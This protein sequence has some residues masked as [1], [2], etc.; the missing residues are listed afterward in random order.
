MRSPF[1]WG[2]VALVVALLAVT[3]GMAIA[4]SGGSS[5]SS[6]S[7]LRSV[8]VAI[9][10]LEPTAQVM[11]AKERGF[12][13]EQ[14][15]DVRIKVLTDPTQT[16]AA[17]LSGNAQFSAVNVG[18]LASMK[19]RDLPVRVVAAG[20]LF[21]PGAETK[22]SALVAMPAKNIT[23]ARDLVGK[24][25]AIDQENTIAHIGV[26]KW[27]KENGVER[28]EVS[29]TTLPFAQMLGPL[30]KGN[31][32][33]ALLPEPF[34][35]I[36]EGK[37]ARRVAYPFDAVCSEECLLTMWIARK[38]MD[39][40]VASRYRK[41]IEAAAVW[42]NDRS[43]D[44]ESA[45]ILAKYTPAKPALLAKTKRTTFATELEP[46]LAQPWID[47]FAEFGVIPDAFPAGEVVK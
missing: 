3:A 35:T 7:E 20:A 22:T 31:F 36:A 12:F 40:D 1:L 15:L 19:S 37:G 38:D 21:D 44:A 23:S 33:A 41:G 39:S 28:D 26:L 24:R 17:V 10:P 13:R 29:F 25:I 9:L 32:D 47:T 6:A 14:G 30:L 34:L 18:G 42:A 11:Y 8:D 5:G 16:A 2:V 27:L 43:N 4:R 45:K 46:T